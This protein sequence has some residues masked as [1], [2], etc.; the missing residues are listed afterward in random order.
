MKKML[1]VLICILT[2]F[3]VC[4]PNAVADDSKSLSVG[5]I[6]QFG[7]YEQDADF[8]NGMEPIQWIV[9]DIQDGKAL[10]LSRY[11]LDAKMYNEKAVDVTWEKCTLRLW[12][13]SDFMQT[14]FSEDENAAILLSEVCNGSDQGCYEFST[15]G[16]NDTEDRV[17]IL[18]YKEAIQYLK[19]DSLRIAVPTAYAETQYCTET[20]YT[21]SPGKTFS[22]LCIVH[23][24][25]DM[26]NGHVDTRDIAPQKHNYPGVRPAMRI[27]LQRIEGLE[28]IPEEN[29]LQGLEKRIAEFEKPTDDRVHQLVSFGTYEQDNDNSNGKEPIEWLVLDVQDDRALLISRYALAV[30]KIMRWETKVSW[31]TCELRTWLNQTF[32]KD[33]FTEEEQQRIYTVELDNRYNT[34]N[35]QVFLLSYTEAGE[36][37]PTD[38]S[39]ICLPTAA[40]PVGNHVGYYDDTQ[41]SVAWWTRSSTAVKTAIGWKT[42]WPEKIEGPYEY[43]NVSIGTGVRT[44]R[45]VA[46]AEGVRP[47]IWLDLSV[48]AN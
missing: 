19:T 40:V 28:V 17:F 20:W 26:W 38:E 45:S 6:V 7:V 1:S 4:M 39:R 21:R 34:T 8:S 23:A 32:M 31:E 27:D 46:E 3:S 42:P 43:F 41:G 33:A 5:S 36:Y 30:Q 14:A 37:F 18:S 9:L 48:L 15:A 24:L 13:N 25:G 35:D 22:N 16:S 10:L 29:E 2:I 12:L 11:L 47:A 44:M